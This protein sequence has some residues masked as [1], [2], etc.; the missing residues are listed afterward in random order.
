MSATPRF[1]QLIATLKDT[2]Q[3]IDIDGLKDKLDSS[4]ALVLIDIREPK[5]WMVSRIP[6]ALHL[7]KGMLE[8]DIEKHVDDVDTEIVLYCRSGK[9]SIISADCLQK[10]GYQN[11]YSLK[12]G[13]TDWA[14]FGYPIAE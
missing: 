3:E 14:L 5:E 6:Q 12:G 4:S 13:F 1:S 9:R 2:T 7:T 10:M 8:R 11:V